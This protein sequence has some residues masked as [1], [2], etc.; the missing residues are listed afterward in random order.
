MNVIFTVQSVSDLERAEVCEKYNDP[1]TKELIKNKLSSATSWLRLDFHHIKVDFK[2]SEVVQPLIL[3]GSRKALIF[4][5]VSLNPNE[6]QLP[7][8]FQNRAAPFQLVPAKT[9][10]GSDYHVYPA[11]IVRFKPY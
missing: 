10:F 8:A 1:K 2:E 5:P 4:V 9:C 7:P 6:L 3:S 11:E